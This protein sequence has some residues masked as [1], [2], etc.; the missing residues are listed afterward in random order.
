MGGAADAPTRRG[1]AQV[2]ALVLGQ[3][4]VHG[5]RLVDDVDDAVARGLD[6][7]EARRRV[8]IVVHRGR[9]RPPVDQ[10]AI[11]RGVEGRARRVEPSRERARERETRARQRRVLAQVRDEGLEGRA[12]RRVPHATRLRREGGAQRLEHHPAPRL[13]AEAV[14][15][16]LDDERGQRRIGPRRERPDRRRAQHGG[17][18]GVARRRER[19]LGPRGPDLPAQR[20]VPQPRVGRI[21]VLLAPRAERRGHVDAHEPVAGDRDETSALGRLEGAAIGRDEVG[22]R[23]LAAVRGERDVLVVAAREAPAG[24]GGHGRLL[25]NGGGGGGGARGG[26]RGG[27]RTEADARPQDAE[28]RGP[29]ARS[30]EAHVRSARGSR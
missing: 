8:P 27:R 3:R 20:A 18:L 24:H 26:P 2:L 6:P 4:L 14:R 22:E 9:R 30:A 11:E 7:E 28:H 13:L 23:G 1:P 16:Q 10:R 12:R 5:A 19:P 25:G 17:T 15:R 29:K 21:R